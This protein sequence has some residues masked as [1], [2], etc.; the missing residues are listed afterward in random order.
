MKLTKKDILPIVLI[1]L[2][3]IIG[4]QLHPSLPERVPSHWNIEGE[5]DGWQSKNFMVFFYPLLTLGIYLLMTFLPSIDPLKKNYEKFS[6][7]YF[8]FKIVLTAFLLSLYAFSL[9]VALG[10]NLDIN[11]FILPAISILFISIGIF[12]PRIKRNYFIGIRT[13]WTIHSD[14]V[15]NSTH[16]FSGKVFIAAGAIS[17]IGSFIGSHSFTIFLTAI[18]LAVVLCFGYSYFAFRKVGESS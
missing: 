2:A 16:R 8:W 18:L 10:V 7:V 5:I 1:L 17:L 6:G 13:P 9:T 4:I 12:L 11:Y 15:W 14:S 3:L